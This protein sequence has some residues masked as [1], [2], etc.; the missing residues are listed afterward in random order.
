MWEA[1]LSSPLHSCAATVL[2]A[3]SVS[4]LVQELP[5]GRNLITLCPSVDLAWHNVSIN[6]ELI[7]LM[8]AIE[9]WTKCY[10]NTKGGDDKVESR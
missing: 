7:I 6:G 8:S 4:L 5:K 1:V 10:G 9:S 3:V 2:S